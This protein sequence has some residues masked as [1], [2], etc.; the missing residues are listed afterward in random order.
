M[1]NNKEQISLDDKQIIPLEFKRELQYIKKIVSKSLESIGIPID[2][3]NI[4]YKR[5]PKGISVLG[6]KL[7]S[8]DDEDT[9][10]YMLNISKPNIKNN[11]V[12]CDIYNHADS[13]CSKEAVELANLITNPIIIFFSKSENIIY[14]NSIQ[15]MDIEVRMPLVETTKKLEEDISKSNLK[16][17]CKK[18]VKKI[19]DK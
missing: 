7:I 14:K 2:D 5:N 13:K 12:C 11:K 15:D 3:K 18:L 8:G 10:N 17:K 9:T 6:I 4:F 16:N 1:K 19:L